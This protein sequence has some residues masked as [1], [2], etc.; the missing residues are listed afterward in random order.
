MGT[1]KNNNECYFGSMSSNLIKFLVNSI[2]SGEIDKYSFVCSFN[3][4]EYNKIVY[5]LIIKV[6]DI[7]EN[8]RIIVTDA[9][10]VELEMSLST[11]H[12]QLEIGDIITCFGSLYSFNGVINFCAPKGYY[13]DRYNNFPLSSFKNTLYVNSN[14]YNNLYKPCCNDPRLRYKLI[15]DGKNVNCTDYKKEYDLSQEEIDSF[16]DKDGKLLMDFS[17]ATTKENDSILTKANPHLE[18]NSN[19]IKR[20]PVLYIGIAESGHDVLNKMKKTNFPAGPTLL[21]ERYFTKSVQKAI[22]AEASTS[23]PNNNKVRYMVASLSLKVFGEHYKDANG[24]IYKKI[25][26]EI[27]PITFEIYDDGYCYICDNN[28]NLFRIMMP[29]KLEETTND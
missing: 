20:A 19:V 24:N 3:N 13:I 9:N 4:P 29:Q 25:F 17:G 18:F 6:V 12:E 27:N 5:P 16:R 21:R 22:Y 7:D 1:Y 26:R 10:D 11:V 8:N 23:F 28:G 2:K 15:D 14:D